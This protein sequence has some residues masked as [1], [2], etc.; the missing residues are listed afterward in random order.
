MAC[1]GG[2]H[3]A[4]ARASVPSATVALAALQG[5]QAEL[6]LHRTRLEGMEQR[7]QAQQAQQVEAAKAPVPPAAAHQ[8]PAA[9][10]QCTPDTV[11]SIEGILSRLEQLEDRVERQVQLMQGSTEGGGQSARSDSVPVSPFKPQPRDRQAAGTVLPNEPAHLGHA[12]A[13]QD[14]DMHAHMRLARAAVLA[15][16]AADGSYGFLQGPRMK[17]DAARLVGAASR[18]TGVEDQVEAT[19]A[20]IRQI[21]GQSELRAAPPANLHEVL[22]WLLTPGCHCVCLPPPL[23]SHSSCIP[24]FL[25]V[26][27]HSICPPEGRVKG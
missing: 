13:A 25:T 3:A 19:L 5:L 8:P 11:H 27:S 17:A 22:L 20:I 24:P 1:K 4:H 6:T 21:Q 7:Q 12:A 23:P 10:S 18:C 9:P 16:A 15:A 14:E 26:P 2:R